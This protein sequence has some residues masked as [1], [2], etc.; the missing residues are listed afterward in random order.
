MVICI[1]VSF[2]LRCI[3]KFPFDFLYNSVIVQECIILF[4]H[5]CEFSHFLAVTHFLF[6]CNVVR[7]DMWY[8]SYLLRVV[9]ACLEIQ[10]VISHGSGSMCTGEEDAVFYWG[11]VLWMSLT[12]L[13]SIVHSFLQVCLFF[14]DLSAWVVYTLLNM[15]CWTVPLLP[16]YCPFRHS[17]LSIFVLYI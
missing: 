7:K 13:W 17:D 10:R 2:V 4:P 1:F 11:K 6:H 15:G 8:H 16:Y 14:I 12:C 5:I 3:F 9:K